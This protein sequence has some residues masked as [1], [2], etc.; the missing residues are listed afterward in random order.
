M[1]L[2][3]AEAIRVEL[4]QIKP[5]LTYGAKSDAAKAMTLLGQTST[6]LLR[7]ISSGNAALYGTYEYEVV[8]GARRVTDAIE[9]GE[10]TILAIV[11]QVDDYHAA[12]ST[13]GMNLSANDNH[14]G[15]AQALRRALFSRSLE[16]IAKDGGLRMGTLK[17]VAAL[18]RL[19][20][21]VL[22]LAGVR[23]APTLLVKVSK[24]PEM[25]QHRAIARLLALEGNQKFSE[26]DLSACKQVQSLDVAMSLEEA[27]NGSQIPAFD[28][29]DVTTAQVRS[30]AKAQG[31]SVKE[32]AEKLLAGEG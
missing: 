32:L 29:L 17:P 26:A 7:R 5:P 21:E 14:V 28:P 30:M 22:E 20:D 8:D 27:I 15:Q 23:I 25:Q 12:L 19:P 11:R 18:A 13:L 1:T 4:G 2:P 31:V 24:L 9:R 3:D 10:K 16:D 6:V